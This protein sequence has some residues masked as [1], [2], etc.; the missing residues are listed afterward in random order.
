VSTATCDIRFSLQNRYADTSL[1]N[2][3]EPFG[4]SN[5]A[6]TIS[7]RATRSE[8]D[9]SRT[10]FIDAKAD[11][12]RTRLTDFLDEHGLPRD[13]DFVILDMEPAEIAPKDLGAFENDA[14]LQRALIAA[15]E[16]RIHVARQVLRQTKHPGL[17]LGLYQVIVPDGKGRSTS[18]FDQRMRGYVE[19]GKQGM[20]DQ[21]DFIC[22]VLYQR[23]GPDDAPL[24][25]LRTWIDA[26]SRQGVDE[27]LTLTRRN[28]SR[29][30]I[31]PLLSFWVFNGNSQN[32]RDAVQPASIARQLQ[33]VQDAVGVKAIVFWSAW[34]TEDEM[35]TA[36]E[37][38]G[39]IVI[40]SFL[41]SVGA[42]PWPGCTLETDQR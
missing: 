13:N 11:D 2:E 5:R 7:G 34:Q 10:D 3:L 38:V 25:T 27:S 30:P 26:A 40:P 37:P 33:I 16:R 41:S 12:I 8:K 23:F 4:I 42:L 29:I 36:K 35:R 14:K 31:V 6:V 28:K 32:S 17:Q 24:D 19:A 1:V 22:P 39:E 18:E 21:L 9:I 15:Y 20:Y